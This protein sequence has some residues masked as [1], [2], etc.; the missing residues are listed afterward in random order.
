M[1]PLDF[2][3]PV[4]FESDSEAYPYWGT[5]SSFFVSAASE[6]YWITAR[7]VVENLGGS[8]DTLRI[9]PN[10]HSRTSIPMNQLAV[11][12]GRD[13]DDHDFY[14]LR[15]DQR[16]HEQQVTFPPNSRPR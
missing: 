9:F 12:T 6:T 15:V 4:F 14:V 3:R 7:H 8:A 13:D 2:V 1:D 5:G 10:A 11:S 16:M